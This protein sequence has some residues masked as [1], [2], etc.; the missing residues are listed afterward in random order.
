[1]QKMIFSVFDEKTKLFSVPFYAVTTGEALRTFGDIVNDDRT[2]ISKY[3]G[4]FKLYFL[5]EFE[6]ETAKYKLIPQPAFL[7][8]ATDYNKKQSI[9]TPLQT[10]EAQNA[11]N[12]KK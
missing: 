5:G 10:T 9:S 11:N 1:M 8:H 3:P 4:D 2:L 12:A 7:A 6:E